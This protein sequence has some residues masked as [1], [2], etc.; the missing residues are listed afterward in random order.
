MIYLK[1]EGII[2]PFAFSTLQQVLPILKNNI[3]VDQL[4][5]YCYV[6]FELEI[7]FIFKI[8]F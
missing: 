4:I 7:G 5:L 3:C 2:P 8:S 6:L 1:K